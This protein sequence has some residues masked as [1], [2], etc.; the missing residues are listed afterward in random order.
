[1]IAANNEAINQNV[2]SVKVEVITRKSYGE[3]LDLTNR[4]EYLCHKLI[5]T[6]TDGTYTIPSV[7]YIIYVMI[8]IYTFASVGLRITFLQVL[9]L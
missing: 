9:S 6:T 7:A 1:M 2:P 4:Y 8:S 3:Y 5:V